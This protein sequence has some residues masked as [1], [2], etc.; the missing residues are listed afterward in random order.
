MDDGVFLY[1]SASLRSID[2]FL[3]SKVIFHLD[4]CAAYAVV[5]NTVVFLSL[6]PWLWK[7]LQ[8]TFCL[9]LFPS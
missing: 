8:L 6:L 1:F 5:M 2:P 7:S 4:R 9:M 3:L